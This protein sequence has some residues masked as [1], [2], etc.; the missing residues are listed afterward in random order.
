MALLPQQQSSGTTTQVGDQNTT[1]YGRQASQ[2]T[3]QQ[4]QAGQASNQNTYLPFQ[5]ELQ[6]EA[7]NQAGNFLA[8]GVAPGTEANLAAQ[9]AAFK[10]NFNQT[11]APQLAA[12]Y[13]AGSPAIASA[14]AQGLVD[15]TS[16]VFQNQAGQFN[17]ALGTA[18]NLAFTATGQNAQN[19]TNQNATANGLT[20]WQ[21]FENQVNG[22]QSAATNTGNAFTWGP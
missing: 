1:Q 12:Q 4:Q 17:S 21:S 3:S 10:Q 6:Q 9:S 7:A 19:S 5:Q 18:G 20:D 15:L 22:L 13:G 16:N 11:V 2:N 8:T 14:E